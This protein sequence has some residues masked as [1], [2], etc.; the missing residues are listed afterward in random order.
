MC[1]TI[2]PPPPGVNTSVVDQPTDVP[3]TKRQRL[4]AHRTSDGCKACHAL[5]DPL[6]LP[7]ETY[8][9]IGKY[10]TT[11]NGLTIDPSGTFD[12]VDVADSHAL[13][14]AASKSV[15]VAQ[16]LVRKY[17]GYAMGYKERDVDGSVL[18]AL[19]TAFNSSGHKMR[20]LILTLVTHDAFSTVGPQP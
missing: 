20:D 13:G 1:G 6:G 2:S 16:C 4:E 5:M 3:T 9:A 8:D 14:V 12:G 10:R 17:Y 15:A 11:E 19:A 18:N 7:L